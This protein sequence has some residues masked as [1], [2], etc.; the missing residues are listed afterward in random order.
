MVQHGNMSAVCLAPFQSEYVWVCVP[1]R[2][3]QLGVWWHSEMGQL[4]LATPRHSRG[5][6][7]WK[8]DLYST[9]YSTWKASE[10]I[11][12]ILTTQDVF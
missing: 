7:G 6:V 3:C 9:F 2:K 5:R 12:C 11:V 8:C 4:R 10:S 1:R